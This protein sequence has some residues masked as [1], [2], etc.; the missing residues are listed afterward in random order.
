MAVVMDRCTTRARERDAR[1][2]DVKAS[3]LKEK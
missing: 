2:D 1:A 3:T